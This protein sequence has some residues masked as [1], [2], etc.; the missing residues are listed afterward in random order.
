MAR[1][2]CK[3]KFPASGRPSLMSPSVR[4]GNVTILGDH[5]RYGKLALAPP[6]RTSGIQWTR[7][8]I[9]EWPSRMTSP[10]A[11]CHPAPARC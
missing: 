4:G 6:G 8:T 1:D 7:T 11:S 10:S 5:Q 2:S 9:S 3:N